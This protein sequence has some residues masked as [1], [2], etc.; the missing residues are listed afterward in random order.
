MKGIDSNPFTDH[1]L[2]VVETLVQLKEAMS[3]AVQGHQRQVGH[4]EEF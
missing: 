3:Q 4:N 2:V 1:R